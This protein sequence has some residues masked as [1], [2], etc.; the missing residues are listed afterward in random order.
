MNRTY[1]YEWPKPR[2]RDRDITT[3]PRIT[4]TGKRLPY[5]GLLYKVEA[6]NVLDG[7]ELSKEGNFPECL[8]WGAIWAKRN[9]IFESLPV[10]A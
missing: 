2:L 3:R 6:I 9:E 8:Y 1:I 10:A 7:T 4:T 5:T